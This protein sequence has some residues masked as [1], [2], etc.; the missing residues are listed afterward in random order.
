MAEKKEGFF[1]K[2][3][4][5]VSSIF[6]PKKEDEKE[7]EERKGEALLGKELAKFELRIEKPQS[8]VEENYFWILNFMRNMDIN[9]EKISDIYTAT[10]TSSYFGAV[11]QKKSA[12]EDRA[13]QFLGTIGNMIF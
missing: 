12:Q 11:E 3:S 6:I 13:S 9:V 4:E 7:K 5:G 1:D 10:E 8:G 2:L